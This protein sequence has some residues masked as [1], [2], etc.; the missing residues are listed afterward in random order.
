[1]WSGT[2][3]CVPQFHL[4]G[5]SSNGRRRVREVVP[6]FRNGSD[7]GVHYKDGSERWVVRAHYAAGDW[8][9][10]PKSLFAIVCNSKIR[11]HGETGQRCKRCEPVLL[12]GNV[13]YGFA[14]VPLGLPLEM[15][16]KDRFNQLL[17]ASVISWR[18]K[19]VLV[20]LRGGKTLQMDTTRLGIECVAKKHA[21]DNE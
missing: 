1:M 2:R 4:L 17:H 3:A 5:Q 12:H 19:L 21:I 14:H 16:G 13:R 6:F 15:G 10:S 20:F 18:Y 9:E 11:W 7:K 8:H